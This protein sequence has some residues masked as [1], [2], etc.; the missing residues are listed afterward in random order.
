MSRNFEQVVKD[1]FEHFEADVNPQV[2]DGI[3]QGLQAAPPQAPGDS[4]I[5]ASVKSAGILGKFTTAIISI[6]AASLITATAVWYYLKSE[7]P[8][9]PE[10]KQ[11]KEIITPVTGTEKTTEPSAASLPS[12]LQEQEGISIGQKE[13]G[14]RY[15]GTH[16][17]QATTHQPLTGNGHA[18]N[19]TQNQESNT[20]QI[21]KTTAQSHA[22]NPEAKKDT[23]T[24]PAI[25]V[26][27]VSN[28]NTHQEDVRELIQSFQSEP[29]AYIVA[30]PVIGNAP[31]TVTFLNNGYARS[32][33]WNF[34]GETRTGGS[35]TYT[36]SN[37]GTYKV[38]L[39]ATDQ[40]G[41]IYTDEVDILVKG[42]QTG[43]ESSVGEIQNVF[44]P[45][46]DGFNDVFR[47]KGN[48][49]ASLNG[50]IFSASGKSVFSWSNPDEGWD[51]RI[52]NNMAAEGT[53]YYIIEAAGK[54]GKVY[55]FK[56][57]VRLIK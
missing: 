44:T 55:R 54:D 10:S 26:D 16:Q 41:K 17:N 23:G 45:N 28:P 49:L 56:G 51:G 48:N 18:G 11:E 50:M 31:L 47:L 40:N 33:T 14:K 53:Y 30:N 22:E 9:M 29:V 12:N 39:E 19:P 32:E 35:Q 34:S 38:T 7:K 57:S 4:A 36:F 5:H 1:S 2:W 6:S 42:D 3:R 24:T 37:P 46:G 13:S 52:G 21:N 8:S 20:D 43:L 27:I 25:K 15:D